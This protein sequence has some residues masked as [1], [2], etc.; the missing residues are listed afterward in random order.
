MMTVE[1]ILELHKSSM[2]TWHCETEDEHPDWW[3]QKMAD[4]LGQVGNEQYW[5]CTMCTGI[6]RTGAA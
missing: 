3:C 2:K 4:F 5:A 1:Q 6:F